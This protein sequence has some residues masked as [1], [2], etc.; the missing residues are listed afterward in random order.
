MSRVLS[1][2]S[3]FFHPEIDMKGWEVLSRSSAT[4][5]RSKA[6]TPGMPKL[7]VLTSQ[8][9]THPWKYPQYYPPEQFGFVHILSDEF[10]KC[11]VEVRDVGC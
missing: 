8:H 10:V 9:V 7:H 3:W 2:T 5:V 4:L 11:T 6:S 1:L